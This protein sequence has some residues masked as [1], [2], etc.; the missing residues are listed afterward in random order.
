MNNSAPFDIE[1]FFLRWQENRLSRSES[2]HLEAWLQNS[3]NRHAWENLKALW[4][5]AEPPAA[6]EQ[7]SRQ[8]QWA[9]LSN[10][11]DAIEARRR[12]RPAPAGARLFGRSRLFPKRRVAILAAVAVALGVFFYSTAH[13]Q[14]MRTV[15]VP[16]GERGH[17]HLP[18]GSDV[19][20]NAGSSLKYPA[21]FSPDVRAV[22]LDGEAYFVVKPG[23]IPFE[24]KT[25]QAT[26]RVLGTEFNVRTWDSA[27][28]VFVH[29]GRVHVFNNAVQAT[30]VEV[31]PGQLAICRNGPIVVKTAPAPDALLAWRRGRLEFRNAVLSSVLAEISR[32]YDVSLSADSL[33]LAKRVSA[34]FE[35][36]SPAQIARSLAA[37]LDATVEETAAGFRIVNEVK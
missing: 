4:A 7:L 10:R 6:P 8:A 24:V 5:A 28:Q 22:A 2:A 31:L 35:K 14:A 25:G 18:D 3:E 37:T 19:F 12:P 13:R 11:I 17:V 26:T 30:E 32:A 23:S 29:S 9:R 1:K 27:T 20:L 15:D 21:V 33:L 34:A 36:E 16:L